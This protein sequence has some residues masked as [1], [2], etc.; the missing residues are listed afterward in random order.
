[1][2]NLQLARMNELNNLSAHLRYKSAKFADKNLNGRLIEDRLQNEINDQVKYRY[3][4]QG[5]P[6]ALGRVIPTYAGDPDSLLRGIKNYR[7]IFHAIT[8]HFDAIFTDEALTPIDTN[9]GIRAIVKNCLDLV[10]KG[11]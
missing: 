11:Q 9:G 3:G 7:Y 4:K 10:H 8:I 1:M 2:T 6:I 5:L